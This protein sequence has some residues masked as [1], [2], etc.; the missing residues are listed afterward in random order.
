MHCKDCEYPLW[1]LKTRSCPECGKP[2][3][4]SE[5]DFVANSV[6]Y[7]C[8]YCAQEYYGT[9]A[10]GHL[11]PPAFTCVRCG[12]A[13]SMDEMILRP[14]EGVE[15]KQTRANSMSWLDRERG[16]VVKPWLRTVGRSMVGPGRLMRAVPPGSPIGA[17]WWYA[18]V[19]IMLILFVGA[20]L[21]LGG[22]GLVI[23]LLGKND[24][25][26]LMR[27]G[28]WITFG[29]VIGFLGA[30]VLWGLVTHVLLRMTGE[31]THPIGRTYQ[32]LCYTI[33]ANVTS[34]VP[35]VGIYPFA[36]VGL[37]W[38]IVAAVLAVMAGQQVS[39]RRASLAV[40]AMP[41]V[42]LVLAA[43]GF[44]WL[45]YFATS[46]A[47]VAVAS[48][49]T[50]I[51]DQETSLVLGGVLEYQ[52]ANGGVWPVHA[53]ELVRDGTLTAWD[54][55][56]S[57][58]GTYLDAVPIAG[59]TLA[60]LAAVPDDRREALMVSA[61]AEHAAADVVAYRFGD[62][63]FCYPGVDPQGPPNTWIVILA[64]DPDRNESS[65]VHGHF[66]VGRLDGAT[67]LIPVGEFE[68]RLAEQNTLRAADG[69]SP[70]PPPGEITHAAPA[71]GP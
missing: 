7:C 3:A 11:E 69:L 66:V 26:E 51:Q 60:E 29:G 56:S 23:L 58:S 18:V 57:G 20:L 50:V 24:G 25:A 68:T 1:N 46:Q 31:V 48:A 36:G 19:T 52:Q 61:L 32:A 67:E 5:H 6:R 27:L 53:V 21:P 62:F 9:D 45:M 12:N 63:V 13:I 15:E 38:W 65:A 33:G 37:A 28:A 64:S 47:R 34:A 55:V 4:P 54:F 71:R 40:L 70:L 16:S 14:A 17:A 8:T 30:I 44:V 22:L 49:Q 42:V 35:C 59:T 10:K 41:L 39:G 43:G 2:F